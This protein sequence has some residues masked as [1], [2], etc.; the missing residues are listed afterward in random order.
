MMKTKKATTTT[1]LSLG[2]VARAAVKMFRNPAARPMLV[3]WY[4]R[5]RRTGGP[6]EACGGERL[7]V[8]RDY[9]RAHGAET[10]VIVDD[11]SY[12]LFFRNTPTDAAELDPD[13]CL[14]VHRG[15]E[16]DTHENV[17]GG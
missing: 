6:L 4:D 16:L 3:A 14:E 10:H 7:K 5:G 15:L 9:A 12:E 11:R 17:Q 8:A 2:D 1:E 13:M